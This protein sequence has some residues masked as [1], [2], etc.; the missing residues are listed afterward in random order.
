MTDILPIKKYSKHSALN[1][2]TEI[3]MTV[4]QEYS[5]FTGFTESEVK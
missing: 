5:E 1:M 4:S 3:S 2:F